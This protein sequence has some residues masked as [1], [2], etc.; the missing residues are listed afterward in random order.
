MLNDAKQRNETLSHAYAE[1]HSE[2]VRLK[3]A[4]FQDVAGVGVGGVPVSSSSISSS[5]SY[6]SS[7]ADLDLSAYDPA[8]MGLTNND[9]IDLDLFVY[10]DMG[11]AGGTYTL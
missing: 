7:V 5:S 2:Y 11:A 6:P 3:T 10:P 9:R 8:A 1:L 4:Q